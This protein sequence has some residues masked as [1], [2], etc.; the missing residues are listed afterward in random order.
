MRG[1]EHRGLPSWA[2]GLIA[3]VIIAIG[4]FLA[5]TKELPWSD[6]Y[7]VSAVFG[8]AQGVRSSSPVR[9][10][11]VN[12]GEV[13]GVE[14]VGE[15]PD[16]SQAVKITMELDESARPLHEDATLKLRPRLFL[17][18]NYFVDLQP[19]TPSAAEVDEGHTFGLDR[20]S[21]SVQLDQVLTTLQGDV[22]THLQIL[23]DQFGNALTRYGG[24]EGFQE[25]NRT[26]PDAYRYTAEVNEAFLGTHP[27]DLSGFISGLDRVLRGLGRNEEALK[28]LVTNFRIVTGSFARQDAQLASAI[29]LLPD[30]LAAGEPA[31]VALNGSLPALRAFAR[32][33]L[34]G[35][36]NSPETLRVATPFLQQ[37]G[38]LMTR[39]ELRGLVARLRTTVPEL[40]KLAK[41]NVPFLE[42]TRAL[43][44]CFTE[45]I[46]PWSN[47]EVQ[48]VDPLNVY[49]HDPVGRGYEETAYGIT[50]I[51]GESRTGDANGQHL[52]TLGGGGTNLVRF[53]A[54][55][56][57]RD[58]AFG[59][60]PFPILGAMPR[61]SDSLKTRYRPQAPCER[62]EPPNLEGGVGSPP[63]Q[64]P[65][66]LAS[67]DALTGPGSDGLRRLTTTFNSLG[68]VADLR[69]A[70]DDAAAERLIARAQRGLDRL[71]IMNIDL[72]AMLGEQG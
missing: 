8:A 29:E 51:A 32:E 68:E 20:T 2:V 27:H 16:G 44:S 22:R 59:L 64:E 52:R 4:S 26:A 19:G 31:F 21:Y 37:L 6:R 24:G 63:A 7:E 45:V 69:A 58:A 42:Q 62:Q 9:I 34:P 49:P 50:G 53:P 60:T 23:L 35:V 36:R 39:E 30:F 5:Y 25:L 72:A 48:P 3:V 11:G 38:A 47:S 46:I 40:A 15:Q 67:L 71:G 70:G 56:G 13:T 61:I 1:M 43:S 55:D 28:D 17:E 12:V 10:A 33:A 57:V 18:G 14:H 66:P 65:A 41:A 54:L